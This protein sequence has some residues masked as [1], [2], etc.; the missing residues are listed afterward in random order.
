MINEKELRP[1]NLYATIRNQQ[2][3]VVG[4]DTINKFVIIGPSTNDLDVVKKADN[5]IIFEDLYPIEITLSKISQ[6]GFTEEQTMSLP[7]IA[8]NTAK[9]IWDEKLHQVVLKDCNDG[10]IGQ[11]IK[12][13]HQLQNIYYFLTGKELPII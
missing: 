1:G 2:V 3:A 8:D 5:S 7:V 12:Y 4:V 11:D 13:I 6:L 10:I 9:F